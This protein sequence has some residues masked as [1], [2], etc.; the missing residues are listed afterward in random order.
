MLLEFETMYAQILAFAQLLV[1]GHGC[2][3]PCKQ[4]VEQGFLIRD[5]V[6]SE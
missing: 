6:K 1:Q 3:I 2:T 4:V 5:I